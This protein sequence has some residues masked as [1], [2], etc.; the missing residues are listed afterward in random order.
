MSLRIARLCVA[1]LVVL[2]L[3]GC[4]FDRLGG[5]FKFEPED[6]ELLM[7]DS[8][9]ALVNAAYKDIP[10]GSLRDHHTHMITLGQNDNDGYINEK[11]LSWMH[12]THRAKAMVYMS[13]AGVD[14]Q[15]QA[16]IQYISRYLRLVR[17]TPNPGKQY[18]FAFDQHYNKDGTVDVASTEFYVPN[19][20]VARVA[21]QFPNEF[22]PVMSVHPYRKD[23]LQAVRTWADQGMRMIKWLPNAH[24]I[25][26]ADPEI[27][28]YY[29]LM[30]ELG[31]V[32]L[33][34][35][36]EEQAVESEEDQALGNPLRF[37][38]P[39]D[40]G[41]KIVMAHCGSLG[42][43]E[44]LDNPG[45]GSQPSWKL[46]LR[47]MD[48]PAYEDRLFGDISAM[49]QFNRL[50]TPMTAMLQR[51]DLFPRLV[52][53]SDYPL[54]AV[55][56]VIHLSKLQSEGFITEA[57]IEPLREIYDYNP[58]MFDFVLKRSL[59]LPGTNMG[60]PASVFQD[61]PRLG[62]SR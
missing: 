26:P 50:P 58:L 47:L 11:M 40:M 60:F 22:I 20:Y 41:V 16:D 19:D 15:D 28:D 43:N 18:I 39:L 33:T 34:H 48:E 23:A 13:G 61:N 4:L 62:L 51:P 25:D 38:R 44:D 27:E 59:R 57:Q 5:D 30:R 53:G 21:K 6:A 32:L 10:P 45:T 1:L 14:D 35:I 49:T 52:N 3:P 17:A 36:G 56:V 31:L 55:N 54:P 37:R 46:F 7:S 12:P 2:A 8:A 42:E 29:N 9:R 24:G